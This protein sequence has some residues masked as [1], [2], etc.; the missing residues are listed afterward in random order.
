MRYNLSSRYTCED[1]NRVE[2]KTREL[3][4]LI[5]IEN[6]NINQTTEIEVGNDLSGRTLIF[7]F[8]SDDLIT[9]YAWNTTPPYTKAISCGT[10]NYIIFQ[11]TAAEGYEGWVHIYYQGNYLDSV[12]EM[13]DYII[14]L[15]KTNYTLPED[16]GEVTAIDES[17]PAPQHIKLR[18]AITKTDW[19]YTDIPLLSDID[20]VKNNIMLLPANYIKPSLFPN[21]L[22]GDRRFN[23][24]VANKLEVALELME[25]T[26]GR[27]NS[28]FSS[29]GYS[30]DTI[31]L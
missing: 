25:N 11:Q 24:V 5:A 31:W 29:E 1:I 19:D 8:P 4:D 17:S 13:N 22:L 16:F 23:F 20:R 10:D 7:N 2:N 12:Y 30:G 21:L 9:P 6:P 14:T 15:N 26:I 28:R 27:A 3:R 18:E